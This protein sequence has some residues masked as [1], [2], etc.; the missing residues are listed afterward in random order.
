MQRPA[1]TICI[2]A[3]VWCACV[4]GATENSQSCKAEGTCDEWDCTGDWDCGEVP[5]VVSSERRGV[6]LSRRPQANC[7]TAAVQLTALAAQV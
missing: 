6:G 3:C 1:P 5:S 2:L 4:V 7:C